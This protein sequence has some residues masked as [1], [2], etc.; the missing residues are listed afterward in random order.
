MD[1]NTYIKAIRVVELSDKICVTEVLQAARKY[2][3]R[4]VKCDELH[5]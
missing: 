1:H 3:L 5:G 2:I 4:Q